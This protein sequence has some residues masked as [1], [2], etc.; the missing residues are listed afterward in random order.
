MEKEKLKIVIAT[1]N[2]GKI[3]EM[4]NAFSHLPVE[5]ISLG[6]LGRSFPD[7]VEDGESFMA[8]S[9]I[10][11]SFYM[12]ETGLPCLADDSGLE[13]EALEGAPGIFSARYSGENA[14]D[15]SNNEKLQEE[16][17]KKGAESSKAAYQC[18]LTFVDTDGKSLQTLGTCPGEIRREAKGDGGFGYDPYFYIGEKSMA[19]LSLEEKDTVSHRGDAL[20]KMAVLL[21]EYLK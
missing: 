20:R 19:Q 9:L 17:R 4:V 15:E 14:T 18:A 21:E 3:K 11:A 10:K 13:V 5:L 16:L 12:K 1:K 8:N 6:D 7:A 2:K